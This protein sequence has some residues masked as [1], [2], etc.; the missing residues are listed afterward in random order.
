VKDRSGGQ[1]MACD[2]IINVSVSS[3]R[4][5][6]YLTR[7]T[8]NLFIAL[9]IANNW[10]PRNRIKI[11]KKINRSKPYTARWAAMPGGLK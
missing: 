8:E 6:M 1:I 5:Y 4:I 2:Q 10:T 11:I 3:Q 7:S 9:K